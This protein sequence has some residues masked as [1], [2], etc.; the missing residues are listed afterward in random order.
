M[1]VGVLCIA[2]RRIASTSD[3]ARL[4]MSEP[5]RHMI[6]G[7]RARQLL[8]L[9]SALVGCV[10]VASLILSTT[11]FVAGHDVAEAGAAGSGKQR[12]ARSGKVGDPGWKR[13]RS[14]EELP[15]AKD[16]LKVPAAEVW[17]FCQSQRRTCIRICSTF[18][19]GRASCTQ[20]CRNLGQG[21][22][23][24]GCFHWQRN[25][26]RLAAHHQARYCVR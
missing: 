17:A 12:T 11:V 4:K 1:T 2:R 13:N 5:D 26:W 10:V 6:W 3:F 8:G 16:D 9:T 19:R 22:V 20:S 24:S 25:L 23:S 15:W 14:A 21:C 18:F 7:Q